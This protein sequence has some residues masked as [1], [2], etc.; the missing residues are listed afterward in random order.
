MNSKK[1]LV[2]IT[3]TAL[4]A[5]T[6][7]AAGEIKNGAEFALDDLPTE[8]TARTKRGGT[9]RFLL[10][11]CTGYSWQA[12]Y[13][14]SECAVTIEH[15][16]GIGTASSTVTPGRASVTIA[17]HASVQTPVLVELRLKQPNADRPTK[18]LRV[19]TYTTP[20]EVADF[21]Y[22]KSGIVGALVSECKARGIVLMDW[23]LHIRGV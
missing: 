9:V 2:A 10:E 4:V 16:A 14:P 18:T 3:A 20:G 8:M 1:R 12:A 7:H 21:R 5:L 19:V 15:R 17:K 6:A 11:E 13:S 22:P 23:H